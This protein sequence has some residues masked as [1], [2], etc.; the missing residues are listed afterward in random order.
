MTPPG[1]NAEHSGQKTRRLALRDA[2][3]VGNKR[4]RIAAPV[5]GREV[6]P[7][8]VV[9]IDLERSELWLWARHG[10]SATISAPTRLPFGKTRPSTAGKTANAA[11]LISAKSSVAPGFVLS[12]VLVSDFLSARFPALAR[13]V[14]FAR[15]SFR[16]SFFLRPAWS[17]GLFCLAVGCSWGR[18]CGLTRRSARRSGGAVGGQRPMCSEHAVWPTSALQ[19]GADVDNLPPKPQERWRSPRQRIFVERRQRA[20]PWRRA[21]SRCPSCWSGCSIVSLSHPDWRPVRRPLTDRY[22]CLDS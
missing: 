17:G 16:A 21:A 12:P 19:D 22:A 3:Q 4:N 8:P 20:R 10:L 2:R 11:R 7:A 14:G 1:F 6:S 13:G 15:R 9:A 18:G 5:A